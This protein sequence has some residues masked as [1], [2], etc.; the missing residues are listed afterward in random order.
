VPSFTAQLPSCTERLKLRRP[1]F[2]PA[3]GMTI[4]PPFDVNSR[5]RSG[6]S[7]QMSQNCSCVKRILERFGVKK[8]GSV[9]AGGGSVWTIITLRVVLMLLPAARGWQRNLAPLSLQEFTR[10]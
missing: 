5:R 7:R 6:L 2:A 10:N 8:R 3:G 4:K 1:V 9:F